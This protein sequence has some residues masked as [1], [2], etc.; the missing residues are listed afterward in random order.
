MT[1]PDG[2]HFQGMTPGRS[3]GGLVPTASTLGKVREEAARWLRGNPKSSKKNP[4]KITLVFRIVT[5]EDAFGNDEILVLPPV[6]PL[7]VQASESPVGR[8][9]PVPGHPFRRPPPCTQRC[10]LARP[11]WAP[12]PP[13]VRLYGDTQPVATELLCF[14]DEDGVCLWG[15]V[16]QG[17][18][19][20]F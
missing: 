12:P 1:Q 4:H 17:Q 9:R 20:S 3:H 19:G 11:A 14:A 5:V 16:C 2:T 15:G 6:P 10:P 18:E 13:G 7:P 8:A